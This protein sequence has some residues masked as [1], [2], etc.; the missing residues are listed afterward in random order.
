MVQQSILG[1]LITMVQSWK[2]LNLS[3]L[4][5]G[6]LEILIFELKLKRVWHSQSSLALTKYTIEEWS[7]SV[8]LS[9]KDTRKPTHI[10]FK[11]PTVFSSMHLF[12]RCNIITHPHTYLLNPSGSQ[13]YHLHFHSCRRASISVPE[14]VFLLLYFHSQRIL[15][16]LALTSPVKYFFLLSCPSPLTDSAK[17]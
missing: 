14:R 10:M 13:T 7:M 17:G 12:V 6:M 5:L 16:L 8:T 3:A 4:Y 9:Q 15:Q 1:D 2:V 11:C